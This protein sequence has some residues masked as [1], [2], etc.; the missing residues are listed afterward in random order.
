LHYH[1]LESTRVPGTSFQDSAM[2][3]ARRRAMDK[4][5]FVACCCASKTCSK[6]ECKQNIPRAHLPRIPLQHPPTPT[7]MAD[8]SSSSA[9]GGGAAAA[10]LRAVLPMGHV[11]PSRPDAN[12]ALSS[13]MLST[14]GLSHRLHSSASSGKQGVYLCESVLGNDDNGKRGTTTWLGDIIPRFTE[15]TRRTNEKPRQFQQRR[16]KELETFA[17]HTLCPFKAIIKKIGD[18]YVLKK[19][20]HGGN[21]TPHS[22]DCTAVGKMSTAG[23]AQL[24]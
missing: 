13:A 20:D 17:A 5:I 2:E 9:A 16:Q 1:V 12:Q 11:Y 23:A 3:W 10:V 14:R 24:L 18:G 19:L 15:P 8:S 6:K 22:D 4:L 21:F 7:M